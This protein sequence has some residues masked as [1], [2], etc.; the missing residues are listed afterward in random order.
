MNGDPSVC[1]GCGRKE[2]EVTFTYRKLNGKKYRNH[3][4]SSCRS[5]YK[6][7]YPTN[8]E[9]QNKANKNSQ[10]K[11]KALRQSG[12]CDERFV[13]EDCKSWDKKQGFKFDLTVEQIWDIIS[14][15]CSY[16]G[17]TQ[18]K[19]GLDRVDNDQGHVLNNVVAACTRCNYLK[20]DMPQEAWLIMVPSVRLARESGAFGG[21]DGFGRKRKIG[22]LTEPGIVPVC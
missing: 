19:I 8:P 1:N 6:K 10:E 15:G 17:E 4:C 5:E 2:P 18:I 11:K 14:A 3:L 16:C 21:W 22:E 13:Y 20:R 9:S 7:K 12:T